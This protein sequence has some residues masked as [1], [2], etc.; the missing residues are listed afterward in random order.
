[1]VPVAAAGED[2]G[3]SRGGSLRARLARLGAGDASAAVRLLADPVLVG[4]GD[5]AIDDLAIA[6]DVD[7]LLSTLARAAESADPTGREAMRAFV[8][9]LGQD[10][11]LRARA[12]SVLGMSSALGDHLV[13][14]PGD[15]VALLE[16][17]DEVG[18]GHPRD[19]LLAAVGAQ[20][21][22][23]EPRAAGSSPEVL[24]ALRVAYHRRL[25]GLA[26]DDL[27]GRTGFEGTAAGLSDLAGAALEAALAIARAGSPAGAPPCR[28]AVVAMG[29][30]GGRELNYVSDVDVLFVGAAVPGG[31]EATA[32]RTATRLAVATMRACQETTAEGTLWQVDAN[33]RPEGR[34]G[35]LVRT[36][37]SYDGYYR[38]W[39]AT[40]EF[41]ALLKARAV[42]GDRELGEQFVALTTPMVWSAADREGFVAH[43]RT[44]RR[45][46]EAHVSGKDGERE[47]KLG[48]GGLRDVEFSVQ[49]LQLV[50]GRSDPTLRSATTLDALA[51]LAGGGYVGRDDAATLADAYRFLRTLEH[52]IQL[53]RLQR[54]HLLPRDEPALRRIGRSM[55]FRVD[56]VRDLTDQWRRHAR[57][58]RR[59]HEKLFY[60]PLLEA[61]ASLDA[62]DARLTV[63]AAGQ[64]LQAL[65]YVDPAGALRNLQSLSSGVSRRAAIQRTLLPVMLGWF[66]QSPDPDAGL[67]A[68]RQVSDALGSSHWYLRLLRDESA[69]AERMAHVLAS[70]KYAAALLLRAPEAVQML[71]SDEELRPR[72]GAVLVGEALSAAQRHESPEGAV[73]AV[74]ALRRRELFRTAVAE[75]VGSAEVDE[76]AAALTNVADA[77]I[78]GALAAA[79]RAVEASR[80]AP[81]ST[82]FA[83]VAM[84][85]YGGGELGFASDADV[86]FVHDPLPGAGEQETTE[87]ALAVAQEL[88]RLLRLPT[89]DPPLEI[90]ADLRPEGRNGPL[91]RSL[92]SYAAYYRRWSAPWEAQALLRAK[93]VAGDRDLGAEFTAMID[94]LRY[95]AGG[96]GEDAVREVRR[97]KARMEAE[98]LPRGADPSLH[99]KLGRGGLTD[100]EW[101]AQLVSMRHG[102]E[103]DGLRTTR[104][105]PALTA[106]AAAGLLDPDDV[107]TLVQ[108]WRLATRIRDAVMLV[109]GRPSDMVPTDHRTLA[110]VSQVLGYPPG[111]SGELLELYRRVS[112]RAR[113]VV[114]R[115]FYA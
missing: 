3:P 68:F 85:R 40:W 29:K 32:L 28:L 96:I 113:T 64:R 65:G 84:G 38:R 35:A 99:T 24:S 42:G 46:V 60:R 54:T 115:V 110:Q 16:P 1:M 93:A 87:A 52:R 75:L 30:C 12:Y 49:L 8:T 111:A 51:A 83:V 14:H 37:A 94:P 101:V 82:R 6:P 90:D 76:V 13:R 74:R 97:L 5:V 44:M 81:L 57:E 77:T 86:L 45:R 10:G 63:E 43:V 89:P 19:E 26:A 95:P 108:A 105:V 78:A 9:R 61:V 11:E 114:E 23:D 2:R 22:D 36:P 4:L 106:A 31:D 79:V 58:V 55:G 67:T 98:R 69:V 91:V 34:D 18:P 100:V 72:T 112:R 92:A 62:G 109:S 88:R 56:P 17:D 53:Y 33:L 104:T 47:L 25:M 15:W 48:P 107:D 59:I 103:L 27:T 20:P 70:S 73:A 66:A 50:H 7:L 21:G 102:Y 71:A 80:Q 39:A 41:Q